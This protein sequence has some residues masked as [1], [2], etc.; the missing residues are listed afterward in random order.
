MILERTTAV[1]GRRVRHLEAGAGRP[2]VLIHGFPLSAD[3]WRPQLERVPDGWRVLAPDLPGFGPHPGEAAPSMADFARSVLSWMDAVGL[4]RAVIG[5][6]S[7]GG[8][9][10]LALYRLA[11]AR[12]TG[13]VLAATKATADSAEGQAARDA[14]SRLV[15]EK[16]A[17]AVADQM[18]PKLLGDAARHSRPDLPAL[19]RSLI[20]ANQTAGIDGAI[21]AMKGRPDSTALLEEIACPALVVAAAADSLMPAA[22]AELMRDR[23]P[24]ARLVTISG[25]GHLVNLEAPDEFSNALA[26]FLTADL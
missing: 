1:D 8:Y 7:M 10:T 21:A 22:E 4:E 25:A 26:T 15:R 6:L 14:M 23:L 19:V 5:G 17:P 3:M 20:E 2:L 18:L 9:V 13:V 24:H 12:V 16:G 11:P